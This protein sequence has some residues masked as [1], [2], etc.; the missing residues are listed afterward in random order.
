VTTLAAVEETGRGP[1]VERGVLESMG[2]TDEQQLAGTKREF[3]KT[4]R[5]A[6][7]TI[8]TPLED[9]NSHVIMK[10]LAG[11]L[12]KAARQQKLNLPQ[13]PV[14][15][16]LPV[17]QLNAM[18]IRVP[19][20]GKHL[21]AFQDGV[22]GFANLLTKAVA[23]SFRLKRIFA[24]GEQAEFS[25]KLRDF[26]RS[27]AKDDEPLRRLGQFL[28]AY[29]VFGDA[30][31]ADQYFAQ[32][33]FHLPAFVLREGFELFLFGH[34][35]GHIAAGHLGNAPEAQHMMGAMEVEAYTSNWEMEFE[36]DRI[37]MDLA[38]QAM[39]NNRL[40]FANSYSGI[41][42]AFSAMEILDLAKSTLVHGEPIPAPATE[43][44]PRHAVRRAFLRELLR[45]RL[46]KKA[47]KQPIKLGETLEEVLHQ[48]WR[49]IEPRFKTL[50]AEGDRPSP[51]WSR[52]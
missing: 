19:G 2:V 22:F 20:S 29:L 30:N 51:I 12:E 23:T 4:I 3:R 16:S 25:W 50:H 45:R 49:R 14:Y 34:E 26:K 15:G 35:L 44:H 27:W 9:F 5:D 28:H 52:W 31:Q 11:Q 7:K 37:G 24:D 33:P 48:M 21:I 40:D 38:I 17:G 6:R 43:S 47:A 10:H 46:G 18:A 32:A 1:G 41:D 8:P 36:A 13:M 42:M 39:L